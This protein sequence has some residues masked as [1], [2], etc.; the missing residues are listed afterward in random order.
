MVPVFLGNSHDL[1]IDLY[2]RDENLIAEMHLAG[3]DPDKIEVSVDDGYLTVSGKREDK[4]E[5]KDKYYYYQEV[6]RGDF[7]R[8]VRLPLKVDE[9]NISAAYSDG[10]L[11]VTMPKTEEKETGAKTIPIEIKGKK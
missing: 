11:K 8:T 7:H 1:A 2:E 9:N 4:T 10:V 6:I 3:I 5:E